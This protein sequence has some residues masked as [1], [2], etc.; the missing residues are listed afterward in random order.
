[1]EKISNKELL[2]ELRDRFPLCKFIELS[3]PMG[4]L[5]DF[6][7]K[8]NYNY[9]I[10]SVNYLGYGEFYRSLEQRIQI[11]ND[12][13]LVGILESN[14]KTNNNV[15]VVEVRMFYD[16]ISNFPDIVLDIHEVDVDFI[17]SI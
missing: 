13:L 10:F 9:T 5:V 7:I 11:Y 6:G 12:Q 17:W 3:K 15:D 2:E 4:N 14:I 16:H 8:H 1:M